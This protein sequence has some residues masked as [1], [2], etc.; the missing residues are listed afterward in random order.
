MP[1]PHR[2][3]AWRRHTA[4]L[5]ILAGLGLAFASDIESPVDAAPMPCVK[6]SGCSFKKP[7]FVFLLDYSSSMTKQ[8]DANVTRW[9]AVTESIFQAI[10]HDN[11]YIAEHFILSLIRFGHDPD[12]NIPGTKIANDTSGLVDGHKVDVPWYDANDPNKPYA[13]CSDSDAI[14]TA[15]E[16]IGPPAADAKIGAWTKGALDFTAAQIA[17]A[18]AD[19]PQD[20]GKRPAAVMLLTD[21]PWQNPQGNQDLAPA[22]HNPMPAAASLWMQQGVPTYVVAFGEALAAPWTDDLA[23]A[24]GTTTAIHTPDPQALVDAP[25]LVIAD[26]QTRLVAP[27]CAPGLP[28]LMLLVDASSSMLNIDGTDKHAPPGMGPWDQIRDSLAGDASIF[29]IVFDIGPL[30]DQVYAGLSVFGDD[31]PPEQ[32]LLVQYGACREPNV[33]WALSPNSSCV[34][35]GCIDPYAAPPIKWTVVD[36]SLVDPPDFTDKTLSHMPRCDLD[37]QLP[38]ACSGSGTFTHLGL[39]LVKTNIAAYKAACKQPDAVHPCT[40]ATTFVN[41]L[42]TDGKYDST[43][44]QVKLPLTAMSTGGVTTHVIGFGSAV[45]PIQLGNMADWGSGNLLDPHIAANQDAL[46]MALKNILTT[47][48]IDP[49]CAVI[50]ECS[51][52]IPPDDEPDP[53]PVETTTADPSTGTG[54]PSTTSDTSDTSEPAATTDASTT[55]V[56]STTT[57]STTSPSTTTTTST[58]DNNDP[59]DPLPTTTLPT[60]STP[61]GTTTATSTATSSTGE[62]ALADRG[63]D[64]NTTNPRAPLALLPLCLLALA[65]RRRA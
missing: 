29:D 40:D 54:S 53:M 38:A 52:F 45:D 8:F 18:K 30:E 31:N 65:R 16:T 28:R 11:G 51:P 26:I 43:D 22:N 25:K 13:E 41:I 15:L 37:P 49:C 9:E 62:S 5:G 44:A 33:E 6:E 12:P 10:D 7:L 17:A 64:C 42:I 56:P 58:T 61:P 39:N 3:A 35:P 36:G 4:Q 34:Q 23:L 46:E 24:G 2:F 20:M 32:T 55:D 14:F 21:G 47:N 50:E 48:Q 27:A 19:H 59:S 60:T 1:H 57:P 63:C